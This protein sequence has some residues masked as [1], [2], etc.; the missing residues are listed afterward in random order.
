[1]A[2]GM[3]TKV[4]DYIVS[5]LGM[6]THVNYERVKAGA[7]MLRRH[8]GIWDMPEP[9]VASMLDD[10]M[11]DQACA[12]TG[13]SISGHTR[14]E[15][16]AILAAARAMQ[17]TPI[18]PQ[19][20]HVLFVIA[21]TKGN[22]ELLGNDST[23]S[24][25]LLL[26]E[27]AKRITRW[28]RNPNE[29]LVVCNACISGLDAQ[30]QAFRILETGP[31]DHAI[32]IGA[33]VLSPFI[34]SGFQSLKAMSENACR[35]F[36]EDRAG[37]NLGEA[38]ACVIYTRR[39]DGQETEAWHIA[40]G[41]I[42]NDAFHTSGPSKTAEGAYRALKETLEEQ[43]TSDLAFINVHGT[44]T[45]FNDE[46][47]AT[48]IHRM[49]LDDIP[50]NGLKG[51][52]GHT[53]GASGV[54]ETLISM[55]A[56]EDRTILATKGFE[57]AGVS[58][59]ANLSGQHRTATGNSFLKMMSGFGGCNACVLFRKGA[60]RPGTNARRQTASAHVAHT[61]RMTSRDVS[62]DGKVLP[63]ANC[64]GAAMLKTL[65]HTYVKDYPKFHKMDLLCK[66]G[67]IASELLLE[68]EAK[69]G[70]SKRFVAREDRAVV[71][72]GR[73]GSLCADKSYQQTIQCPEDYYP[74]PSAFIYTLPNIVAGEVAIR[75]HYHGETSY[76]L[77]DTPAQT[78]G[79][80]R[81]ALSAPGTE[82]VIG[83]W[84]E[85]QS[86]ECFEAELY[87]INKEHNI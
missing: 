44:A 12:E 58:H 2:D 41:S 50:A 18:N 30:L 68:A 7:S 82:S 22:V 40:C 69:A 80:V 16:I 57:H 83:G 46:M 26:P 85:A 86:P 59:P 32:V 45:L 79:L 34:V 10:G 77:Q 74:S 11:I 6:G 23:A 70:E 62:L 39:A 17:D 60:P 53:L 37:L 63:A 61:V 78:A 67:F 43:D 38:A 64:S 19:S 14:F 21:T 24:G 3:I 33:D 87:I 36:D 81:Q 27:A 1:M 28:F 65:Y 29:P 75:N 31:Y 49:G 55:A 52:F 20:P 71:F 5:P 47:E 9:F 25:R 15:R 72:V 42:R 51:Y 8:T 66:L 73:S 84:I 35:P 48:A 54:L 13:I 56:V 76:L 4:S